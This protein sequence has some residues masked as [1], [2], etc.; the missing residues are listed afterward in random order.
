MADTAVDFTIAKG[1]KLSWL[2][3]TPQT[4]AGT[5][6][7]PSGSVTF[8]IEGVQGAGT[9]D[10]FTD[11]VDGV[12]KLRYKWAAADTVTPGFYRCYFLV[13]T[14]STGTERFPNNDVILV[15]VFDVASSF[16]QIITNRDELNSMR[17][18]LGLDPVDF[19]DDS[20]QGLTFLPAAELVI[21]RAVN[22]MSVDT[23]GAVPTVTQI[24]TGVSP[25]TDDDK[26]SLKLAV[27]AYVAYR[28]QPGATNA[29]DVS[30]SKKV[31]PIE[32]NRDRGGLGVQWKDVMDI[33]FADAGMYLSMI[34]GWPDQTQTIFTL[35]G[36]TSSGARPN[37]LSGFWFR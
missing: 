29:V 3:V 18:Y 32:I 9:A 15:E 30:F 10:I 5:N 33:A 23:S 17:A 12:A 31:G 21:R 1:D 11:S 8:W 35:S 24:M 7:V 36:P 16:G 13:D 20:I 4:A 14:G 6:I 37:S 22:K 2:V 34:T 26:L 27:A 28:F 25:A 19:T